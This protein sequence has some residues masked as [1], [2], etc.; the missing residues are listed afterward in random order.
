MDDAELTRWLDT[1]VAP[2]ES[3]NL[4]SNVSVTDPALFVAVLRRDLAR[5]PPAGTRT[6]QVRAAALATARRLWKLFK[7]EQ[8]R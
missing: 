7:D 1:W 2:T 4:W 5:Q 8:R 6:D 3:F